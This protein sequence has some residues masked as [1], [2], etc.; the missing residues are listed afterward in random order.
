LLSADVVPSIAMTTICLIRYLYA[1]RIDIDWFLVF[2]N[3]DKNIFLLLISNIANYYVGTN[4]IVDYFGLFIALNSKALAL[5]STCRCIAWRAVG[6]T[7]YATLYK[8]RCT[9]VKTLIFLFI[10]HK[11]YLYYKEKAYVSIPKFIQIGSAV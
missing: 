2:D 4:S 11:F 5:K 9:F 1:S 7:V 6:C 10:P 8:F 3:D